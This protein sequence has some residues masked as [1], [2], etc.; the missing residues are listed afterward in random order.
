MSFITKTD[1]GRWR[2]RW[3]TP[4]GA[5]RSQTFRRKV[6]AEQH[7]TKVS[8]TKLTGAYVDPGAGKVTF[9]EVRERYIGSGA[10]RESTRRTATE[11]TAAAVETFGKRAIGSIRRSELQAFLDGLTLAPSTRAV[12][13]QHLTA[14]FELAVTDRL[15]VANPAKRLKLPRRDVAPVSPI[16]ADELQALLYAAP[17]RFRVAL[18]LGAGLGLRLGEA[19]GLTVDRI[20]FLRRTVRVDRQWQQLKRPVPGAFAPPKSQS[21]ARIIPAAEGV[22][23]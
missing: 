2:A 13:R 21:S 20:D 14:V 22:L 8:H 17:K 4:E 23:N 11:R 18:V 3:R 12:V 1:Q 10:W 5:E 6:D 15:I 7:L 9:G 19:S 16:T